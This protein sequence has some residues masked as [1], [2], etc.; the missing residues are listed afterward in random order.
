LRLSEFVGAKV[1]TFSVMIFFSSNPCLISSCQ[2]LVV[3][4]FKSFNLVGS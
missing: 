2:F 1:P 3:T 4:L